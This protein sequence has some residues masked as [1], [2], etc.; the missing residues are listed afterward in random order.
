MGVEEVII[1]TKLQDSFSLGSSLVQYFQGQTVNGWFS[2]GSAS[3]FL[4]RYEHQEALSSSQQD[5]GFFTHPDDFEWQSETVLGM[6]FGIEGGY[7]YVFSDRF[8]GSVFLGLERD[9]PGFFSS[10]QNS[11]SPS[12]LSNNKA[13]KPQMGASIGLVF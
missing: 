10:R 3:I 2:K 5:F 1:S 9:V 4:R 8:S 12:Y 11:M 13:W 6:T 7:R